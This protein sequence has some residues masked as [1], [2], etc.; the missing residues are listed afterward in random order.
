MKLT[1]FLI[2]KLILIT[3]YKTSLKHNGNW[4]IKALDFNQLKFHMDYI[5]LK[6]TKQT[7]NPLKLSMIY[8]N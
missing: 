1:L 3:I 4:K 5:Q 7:L 2:A 8:N 6:R